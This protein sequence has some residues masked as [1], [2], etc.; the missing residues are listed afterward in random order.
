MAATPV[1][2]EDPDGGSS[3]LPVALV[4]V[5]L[6]AGAGVVAALVVRSRTGRAAPAGPA[7]RGRPRRRPVTRARPLAVALLALALLAGTAC[8]GSDGPQAASAEPGPGERAED[9]SVDAVD[10]PAAP[11]L[12]AEVTSADGRTIRI[13]DVSRIVS[14]WGNI[15]ETVFALGLGDNVVGRDVASTFTEAEDVPVVTRAHDVSPEA[16]LSLRPTV[17][18]VDPTIG[19]PEAIDQIRGAGVP[20]VVVDEVTTIDGIGARIEQIATALGV[21]DAG[22]APGRRGRGRDRGGVGHRPRRR[23]PAPRRLPL[24]AGPGRRVPHRRARLGRRRD[25]RGRRRRG[26]RARRSGSTGPSPRSPA[27]PSPRPP[28]T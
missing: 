10:G 23:R 21:P 24:H 9:R 13:D 19:P 28:P 26:R 15:T 20:V 18:L 27:R 16:V 3:A 6:L 17:V 11:E 5:V 8:A 22:R 7:D 14:L 4:L 1:R 12:P 25:D 2:A